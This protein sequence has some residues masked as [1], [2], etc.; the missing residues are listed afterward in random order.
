[1][2][3]GAPEGNNLESSECALVLEE[4]ENWSE[5]LKSGPEVIHTLAAFADAASA[6]ADG[7]KLAPL[8]TDLPELE[9]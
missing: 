2:K 4:L 3:Y 6:D 9:P 7:H 5:V 1:M 8:A